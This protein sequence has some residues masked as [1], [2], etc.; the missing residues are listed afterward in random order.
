VV[1]ERAAAFDAHD[2]DQG[3]CR[4]NVQRLTSLERV[5]GTIANDECAIEETTEMPELK[6]GMPELERECPS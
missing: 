2:G 1:V 3:S 5:D 6:P 4:R